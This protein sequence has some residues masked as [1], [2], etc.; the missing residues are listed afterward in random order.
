MMSDPGPIGV[1]DSGVG[2]LSV[3]RHIHRLL[4]GEALYY[5]ADSARAPYGPRPDREIRERCCEIVDRMLAH[6]I[7]ALVLAC[8]TATAAAVVELRRRYAIPIVAME[9]GIKPAAAHSRSGVIAVLAT[10]G[11]I[12]S[13]RFLDLRSRFAG[14]VEIITVACH[15]L[16]DSIEQWP[17]DAAKRRALLEHYVLPVLARG[18]DTLILGCTHYPLIMDEI[19]AV[20]GPGVTLLDT[21]AAVACELRRRLEALHLSSGTATVR[22]PAFFTTAEPAGQQPLLSHFWGGAVHPVFFP[23]G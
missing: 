15:G 11:T 2:G 17:G 21:G 7:K 10:E 3:L 4:P 8:N 14:Q 5:L 23:A 13:D 19:Q 18:A 22:A 20:A 16:V 9:P 6:D 12:E 1:L